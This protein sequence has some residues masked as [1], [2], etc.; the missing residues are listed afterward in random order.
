M[1]KFNFSDL[2]FQK[3]CKVLTFLA[4][5]VRN[6]SKVAFFDAGE[7]KLANQANGIINV[8][9]NLVSSQSLVLSLRRDHL[10]MFSLFDH[11]SLV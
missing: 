6:F 5:R 3:L 1:F 2:F 11:F 7:G 9:L 10:F 4:L 8:S